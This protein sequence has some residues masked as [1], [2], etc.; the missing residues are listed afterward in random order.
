M[1]GNVYPASDPSTAIDEVL[2]AITTIVDSGLTANV[3]SY[4]GVA[5]DLITF[6]ATG[7]V[8]SAGVNIRS[9]EWDY[10]NDG[11][12]D[13]S[14]AVATVSHAYSAPH[15]GDI[16]L[17]LTTDQ[18]PANSVATTAEVGTPRTPSGL[19]GH[20]SPSRQQ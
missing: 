8:T 1:G 11:T 6:D 19:D 2:E 14:T 3:G 13:E 4:V 7:S 5:G 12:Y 17:R 10:D 20:A 9:Y 16:G 18:T 15:C